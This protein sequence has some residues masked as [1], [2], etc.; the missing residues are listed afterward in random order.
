MR[1]QSA[2]SICSI[3]H[4]GADDVDAVQRG[5]G[6]DAVV[7]ALEAESAWPDVQL[8]VLG[9]LVLIDDLTHA[10]ADLVLAAGELGLH[11]R[12]P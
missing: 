5:F 3:A 7:L 9:D 10:H 6:G 8:E 12:G 1:T 2:A 4:R 11:Q